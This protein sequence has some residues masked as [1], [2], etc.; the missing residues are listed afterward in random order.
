MWLGGGVSTQA[1]PLSLHDATVIVAYLLRRHRKLGHLARVR[2]RQNGQAGGI[3]H[4]IADELSHA[5]AR[6]PQTTLAVNVLDPPVRRVEIG[7]LLDENGPVADMTLSLVVIQEN[8]LLP[9]CQVRRDRVEPR[10]RSRRCLALLEPPASDSVLMQRVRLAVVMVHVVVPYCNHSR[11][12]VSVIALHSHHS[13]RH[14]A[15]LD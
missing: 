3:R 6:A 9:V 15:V 4:L 8:S 11:C 2:P 1:D 12:T 10:A 5:S 14:L 13:L 7:A